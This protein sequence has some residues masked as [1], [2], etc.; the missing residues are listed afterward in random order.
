MAHRPK[1]IVRLLAASLT[2]ATILLAFA[3][4][5]AAQVSIVP[6]HA[7]DGGTQT[8]AF[9]L[10]DERPDTATT[11]LE[12]VFPQDTPVAYVQV[13]PVPGWTA[14]ITPRPLN[15][16]IKVDGKTISE[17]AGSIVLQG[18]S[19]APD[20]FE[21]FPIT[22]GPLPP[23]GRLTFDATQSFA[24]GNVQHLTGA[25]APVITFG[26][27]SPAADAPQAGQSTVYPT[28]DSP[29]GVS[30]RAAPG[31]T[32]GDGSGLP[33]LTVLWAALGLAI[34]IVAV[35]WLRAR[36]DRRRTSTMDSELL[37]DVD[38][39]AEPEHADDE[40]EGASR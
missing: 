17:V 3:T 26:D 37:P 32:A 36:R 15:P 25:L 19:V 14:T 8:F 22:M 6:D 23:N 34:V 21:T 30:V 9:R 16:P 4:P 20:E 35:V 10:A 5:A 13:D 24:N 18:G 11:R 31:T 27:V 33:A 12:L 2:T 7:T 40:T 39:E 1:I 29:S 38:S 28:N